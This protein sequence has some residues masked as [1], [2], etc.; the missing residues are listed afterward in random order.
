MVLD[1]GS[2]FF[3]YPH[4][5]PLLIDPHG[6]DVPIEMDHYVPVIVSHPDTV[7]HLEEHPIW[8]KPPP[9]PR[10]PHTSY[11][12]D[13]KPDKTLNNADEK[14]PDTLRWQ[15]VGMAVET[16]LA[17]A[18]EGANTNK[19]TGSRCNEGTGSRALPEAG[20]GSSCDETTGN[21]PVEKVDLGKPDPLPPRARRKKRKKKTRELTP[22]EMEK[23]MLTHFP[24]LP[25]CQICQECKAQKAPHARI[26]YDA[27]RETPEPI[28]FGDQVTCDH[29]FVHQHCKS[30]SGKSCFLGIQD[31]WSMYLVAIPAPEKSVEYSRKAIL[32]FFG[33]GQKPKILYSDCSQELRKACKDLEFLADTSTPHRPQSN[34]VAERCQRRIK[35]GTRCVLQQSGL[36]PDWW[37]EAMW[38]YA[39]SRNINDVVE[40]HAKTPYEVRHGN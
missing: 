5:R 14:L 3:W 30:K 36:D 37:P 19:G 12:T 32:H 22:E 33:P 1:R 35:E 4:K 31:R 9:A 20:G 38:Y 27:D 40:T 34:G 21:G 2:G 39:Y 24:S 16:A 17:A 29:G 26:K 28:A 6:R 8:L 18:S 11:Y 15:H 25:E 7:T 13:G 23:H 10:G